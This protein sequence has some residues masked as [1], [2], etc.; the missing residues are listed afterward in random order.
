MTGPEV[1][2]VRESSECLKVK[3]HAM[4]RLVAAGEVPAFKADGS[5][6]RIGRDDAKRRFREGAA[7]VLLCTAAAKGLNF[8]FCGALIN[9]DMHWHPMRVDI[10]NG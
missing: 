1:V 2:T 5:W 8:Q 6:R 10:L 4:Y 9:Y 7:D 3:A